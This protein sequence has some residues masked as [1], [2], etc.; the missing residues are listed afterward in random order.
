MPTLTPH[1]QPKRDRYGR[2]VIVDP[3]TGRDRSWTRATTIAKVLSDTYNLELWGKRMVVKGI[4]IR[5]DLYALASATPIDD[6]DTL[7]SIA[8]Q[9]TDAVAAG[10][11][12]NL[13][14]A[15]HSFTERVDRGESLEEINAPEPWDQDLLAYCEE[16]DRC[17]VSIEADMVERIVT[18][19]ELGI[20]GTF[21]RLVTI[22]GFDLPMIADLKTGGF[23]AWQDFAIQFA[24]YANADSLY[25]LK[26]QKHEPMPEIDKTQALVMHLPVG[27]AKCDLYLLDIA[28][29]WEALQHCMWVRKWQKRK[30]L[31]KPLSP[32]NK[33]K[34]A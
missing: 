34:A 29:G 14:S 17:H 26:T 27:Q 4:G 16:M 30:N 11:K 10:G 5:R 9:A 24:I 7:N 20:A 2:Y 15:L 23:L 12:A 18:L 3:E 1:L 28:A 31:S 25:S 33:G 32:N 6:K 21:D 13:G 8:K 19:H 22:P